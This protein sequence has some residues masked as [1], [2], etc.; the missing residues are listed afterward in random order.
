[1]ALI[2]RGAACLWLPDIVIVV[3]C[4]VLVLLFTLQHIGTRRISFVFAP[5]V[6]AWLFCNGSV[7]VY[8]LVA[9]NPGIVRA[10]SPYYIYKFFKVSRKDGWI[11]LGGILL[12]ITGGPFF[13]TSNS[14]S[15]NP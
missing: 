11:S 15:L 1:M 4:G 14:K 5:I 13:F 8:N 3:S 7:G 10:L 6:L 12:C 2:E 9:F